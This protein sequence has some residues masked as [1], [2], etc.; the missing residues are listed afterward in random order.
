MSE[1]VSTGWVKVSS[2]KVSIS[3]KVSTGWV[4]ATP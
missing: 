1:M 4:K 3:E 2:V